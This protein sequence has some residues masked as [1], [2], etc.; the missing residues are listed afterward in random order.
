MSGHTGLQAPRENL[1][2]QLPGVSL[3][4]TGRDGRASQA[5]EQQGNQCG[6]SVATC[7][8]LVHGTASSQRGFWGVWQVLL[9]WAEALDANL[10]WNSA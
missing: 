10:N 7:C 5:V 8:G 4:R 9:L 3:E 1:P 6:T 2:W